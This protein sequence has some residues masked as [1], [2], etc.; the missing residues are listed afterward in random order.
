MNELARFCADSP[1]STPPS[2]QTHSCDSTLRSSPAMQ[3]CPFHTGNALSC[4]QCWHTGSHALLLKC[5]HTRTRNHTARPTAR[6]ALRTHPPVQ[7]HSHTRT[8]H[9]RLL[10]HAS[11][12][13]CPVPTARFDGHP[14]S[15]PRSLACS[16]PPR[17]YP[18]RS[19]PMRCQYSPSSPPHHATSAQYLSTCT[20]VLFP[21]VPQHTTRCLS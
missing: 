15:A 2:A 18:P 20:P 9:A 12:G 11:T 1:T 7:R 8:S 10:K 14:C 4:A 16:L 17:F 21:H 5:L 3:C 19:L 6:I 13:L